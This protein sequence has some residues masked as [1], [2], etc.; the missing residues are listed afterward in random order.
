MFVNEKGENVDYNTFES[1]EIK[2]AKEFIRSDDYVLELGAR[3]GGVS[4]AINSK[5][6]NKTHQYSVEPDSRVWD[7]LETNKKN[8]NCEFNII[9]GTISNEPMKIIQNSRKFEDNNDWAAYTEISSDNCEII[10]N[11]KLPDKPF[12]VLVA[13]CEGFLETFYNEN[14]DFFD[15][16]RCI[17]IEKDR[18]DYCDYKRLEN[19][20]LEMGFQKVYSNRDFHVVYEKIKTS[21]AKIL[22]INLD[23]RKDRKEHIEK[24]FSECERVIAIKD[25]K[26]YIG[27][28]KSHIKC[29]QLAKLRRYKEV[30]ILEDDFKYKDKRTLEYMKIPENYDMLLL[31]NLIKSEKDIQNYDKDF[32][33]VFK[34]V[35]TS[36]YMVHQKFYQNLIDIFEESLKAL[37]KEYKHCNYLDVYWNRIFKDHLILKHK[38]MIGTQLEN[39]FSNI[40]NKVTKRSN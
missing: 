11:H 10:D 20:F 32:D 38:K 37:E 6:K 23:E 9:K 25:D 18:P 17:M 34:A 16:L 30:I 36:G 26:G 15:K 2:M 28:V 1:V 12:N 35:W 22:Y 4:C 33:R 13:D 5:L 24:L 27:C 29:L 19:I 39:D 40:Q 14:I 31:S 7:A 21:G 8:N 3:Y